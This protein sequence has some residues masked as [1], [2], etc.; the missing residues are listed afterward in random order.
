M[1]YLT[2]FTSSF[3]LSAY[4]Y[5][6][7]SLDII[8]K[9]DKSFSP[10]YT[11]IASY[12]ASSI[13]EKKGYKILNKHKNSDLKLFILI[14]DNPDFN[15][16]IDFNR[17]D[18]SDKIYTSLKV[19][20]DL[21]ET[22]SGI[23]KYSKRIARSRCIGQYTYKDI[24]SFKGDKNKIVKDYSRYLEFTE[25]DNNFYTKAAFTI[26]AVSAAFEK[27]PKCNK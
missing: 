17:C 26:E 11:E 18:N 19:Q 3:I 27:L 9:M 20:L 10:V 5:A 14:D 13:L 4:S 8:V 24:F 15:S 2:L 6:T 22:K 21:E 23:R 16:D 12:E 1:K 25:N 7:C